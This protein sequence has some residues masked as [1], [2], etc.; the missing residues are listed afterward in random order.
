MSASA[1]FI[2]LAR[3]TR[4]GF[5]MDTVIREFVLKRAPGQPTASPA[6][7]DEGERLELRYS[8]ANGLKFLVLGLVLAAGSAGVT[9]LVLE[10]GWT[11][12]IAGG[13]FVLIGLGMAIS[14]LRKLLDKRP[15]LIIDSTGVQIRGAPL[16]PWTDAARVVFMNEAYGRS[17]A[18]P[19]LRVYRRLADDEIDDDD[20]EEEMEFLPEINVQLDELDVALDDVI[21]FTERS[22]DRF[23]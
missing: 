22:L 16:L 18:S 19:Y 23:S 9:L 21:R 10:R 13:A 2:W 3:E 4:T 11:A 5:P 6:D 1:F 12:T 8:R 15:R 7:T 20:T 14:S 17:G